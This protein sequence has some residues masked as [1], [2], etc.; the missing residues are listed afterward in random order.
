M[1]VEISGRPSSRSPVRAV[2]VTSEV[3]SEPELVMNCFEPLTT[4]SPSSSTALVLVAPASEPAPGSV[5][6]KP[7]SLL[8]G[9]ERGQPGL[10]LLVGAVG[11]DRVD[12]EPDRGLER[13]A[14]RLVDAADL[15]DRQAQRR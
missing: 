13:D 5:R 6:P 14:H 10:L 8:A 9:D 15:L 11:E 12:P 3:M 2:T 4:H 1:I 7:A